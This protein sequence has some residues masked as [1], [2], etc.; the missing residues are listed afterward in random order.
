MR[1]AFYL[2][3]LLFMVAGVVTYLMQSIACENKGGVY[4]RSGFSYVCVRVETIK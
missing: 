2:V 1:L 4:L 3:L